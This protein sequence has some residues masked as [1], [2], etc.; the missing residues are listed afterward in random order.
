MEEI[1][2]SVIGKFFQRKTKTLSDWSSIL[3]RTTD[4][5]N[6]PSS[7]PTDK[8]SAI[9]T[10]TGNNLPELENCNVKFFGKW[11]N[12]Q[13][14]GMQFKAD[15][16]EIMAPN[17]EKGLV[18]FLSSKIFPGIGKKTA[19]SIVDKFGND[20]LDVL[21]KTPNKLLAV[22]GITVK[23]LSVIVGA[24]DDVQNFSRLAVFLSTYNISGNIVNKISK[25]LG[26]NA[27]EQI[28]SNPYIL[29]GVSGV[30]FKTCDNIARGLGVALDSLVRIKGGIMDRLKNLCDGYGNMYCDIV[31]LY[32]ETLRLLNEGLETNPVNKTNFED[33]I[34]DL[35]K[36]QKI[37]IRKDRD[38]YIKEYDNAEYRSVQK[39]LWLL[40][41][42]ISDEKKEEIEKA[43]DEYS[44]NSPIK[45][46]EK[47]CNAVKRSLQNRVSVI[48]G[49]PG[50]GK[51]T[52]TA[53]IIN[54]YEKVFRQEITLM[55]PTG[56]A[57]RRMAEC[58]GREASTI[59]SRLQ[60]YDEMSQ[61]AH[62]N[63]SI[64]AGL[65]VVDEVSM[66]DG[67]L[68]EKLMSAIDNVNCHL[69]LVGDID[70]LPSV[71][72]G[73][74]LAEIIRSKVV[75]T[76]KLTEIFRQKNGGVI[77]D[78]ALKINSGYSNLEFNE[79]FV[80]C[81]AY[82][83]NQAI[84]NIIKIYKSEV[85]KRGIDNVALL[86]PL[87]RTQNGRFKCVAD[88]LNKQLQDAIN[89]KEYDKLFCNI[90]NKE[91]R[92][93][94]RVMQW[95]NTKTSSNGDI[96]EVI[97]IYD[98]PDYGITVKIEWDNGNIVEAHSEDLETIDLAY[99]MSVH[100]SQ[101]SE[102]QSVII[103]MLSCQLGK[104]HRRN[105]FYTAVTRSKKKVFIVGDAN[106]IKQSV[107]QSAADDFR[108]TLLADRLIIN[109]KKTLEASDSN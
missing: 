41:N 81:E 91:F 95:R 98:D 21:E 31:P 102:Y 39:I 55:A 45:L 79:D 23:K 65:I 77:V 90:H 104:L 70:Q 52:I 30:G 10:I 67:L 34:K 87:R 26:S 4:I 60:I 42:K 54:V 25:K 74:V 24:Y 32:N 94:D 19:Q 44:K 43:V 7:I 38:V 109:Y 2:T 66:V 46:S 107:S 11:S 13:K 101:G 92:L 27:V 22:R 71:G 80:M 48:T 108:N 3:C 56:K 99:A 84:A 64:E 29:Q 16:Y 83:E 100:K 75:P 36:N 96:G 5:Q 35:Q 76:T 72:P 63:S 50:T 61:D 59:H 62:S 15:S 86:S 97:D 73:V 68:L 14:Y 69:I 106:C 37:V 9:I 20:T 105:M 88:E 33:A 93:N 85:E 82:D 51:S 78:N 103:P 28:Q 40:D 58:T 1:N 53:A 18:S 6:I 57:A 8:G 12:H 17:T 89:P 47:Q 49:G